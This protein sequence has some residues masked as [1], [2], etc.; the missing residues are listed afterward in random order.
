MEEIEERTTKYA[1]WIY[2]LGKPTFQVL[3]DEAMLTEHCRI[4]AV[5]PPVK[6]KQEHENL[7]YDDL[8]KLYPEPPYSPIPKAKKP[9]D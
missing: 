8:K 9:A 2:V 6:I 3:Y 1:F 7:S 5:A 4:H